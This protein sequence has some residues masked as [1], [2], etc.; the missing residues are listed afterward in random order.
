MTESFYPSKNY[1]G[2]Q[3]HFEAQRKER[4][5]ERNQWCYLSNKHIFHELTQFSYKNIV[6]YLFEIIS[7]LQI[8]S[9]LTY[10]VVLMNL[11]KR[12]QLPPHNE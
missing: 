2:F 12:G 4:K 6:S 9:Y 5:R 7:N 1:S 11:N 10:I 3:K 8:K